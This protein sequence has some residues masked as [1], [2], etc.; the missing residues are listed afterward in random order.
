MVYGT[1]QL[2]FGQLLYTAKASRKL[3]LAAPLAQQ[4]ALVASGSPFNSQTPEVPDLGVKALI[5]G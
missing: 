1:R 4:A 5:L 2:S 3:K